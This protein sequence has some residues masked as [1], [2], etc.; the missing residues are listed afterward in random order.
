MEN[1]TTFNISSAQHNA[2]KSELETKLITIF[3]ILNTSRNT[4]IL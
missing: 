2:S 4:G 3:V 1:W